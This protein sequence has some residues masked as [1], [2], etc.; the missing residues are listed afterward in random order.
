V[1]D[2]QAE[3][4]PAAAMCNYLARLGWAHGDD[5]FFGMDQARAWFDLQGIGR[6]PA[7]LDLKKLAH[8]SG[9]HIAAMED[10]AAL[11]EIERWLAATGRP[12]LAPGQREALA[13]ALYCVKE[14]A[15]SWPD[16]LEK[17]HFALT[18]RP[19]TPD[20]AAAKV[21]AG[22]KALLAE[23]TPQLHTASW[24][25]DDLE[26]LV[27]RFAEAHGMKLGKVAQPLRAALAGRT[28][29]PSVFDMMLVIGRDETVARLEDAAA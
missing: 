20:A 1:E 14:R 25:R 7:R 19:V 23:L 17:A 21:V 2:W 5:E 27:A 24:T 15:R 28:A 4:Y 16:L 8:L 18:A 6:A 11:S 26:A 10:A 22:S 29:T 9:L 13:R 12:P 3:G